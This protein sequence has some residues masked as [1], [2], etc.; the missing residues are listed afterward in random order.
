M[1]TINVEYTGDL[2]C[3]AR[4]GPSGQVLTTDAPLD[5]HGKGESFSPTDLVVTAL[6]S[7]MA[8]I[9]GV[10]AEREQVDL[11]GVIMSVTKEM[12]PTPTRRIARITLKIQMPAGL[13][14]EQKVLLE[15][16]ADHCP[17]KQSLHPD[18]K[19]VTEFVYP[20]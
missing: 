2:H 8:T 20:G 4:H 19:I 16:A 3:K 13:T 12:T 1:V 11:T 18:I 6:G 5:N 9:M 17:V 7:C 10:I 15:E 14:K